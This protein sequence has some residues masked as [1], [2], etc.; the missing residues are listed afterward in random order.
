V[1]LLLCAG[2][3]L[4]PAA[5]GTYAFWTDSGTAAGGA[6]SAGTLD[7][8]LGT[9]AVDNDPTGFASALQLSNML[10]GSR[11]DAA[12]T[13]RNSG[14]APFSTTLSVTTD[15]GAT[16]APRLSGALRLWVYTSSSSATPCGSAGGDTLVAS[17]ARPADL[18]A[19]LGQLPAGNLITVCVSAR[20][21]VDA[22][23]G[24]QGK[25]VRLTLR[26]DAKQVMA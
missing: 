8:K 14:T 9:P 6:L 20:L 3:L 18:A 25:S 19:S 5:M 13:L 12:V 17:E 23:Q 16:L 21:P 10:P 22:D 15:D 1:R 11:K 4:L 2:L 26:F 7:L 24:V